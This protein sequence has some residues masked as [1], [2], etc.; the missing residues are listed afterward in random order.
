MS[1]NWSQILRLDTMIEYFLVICVTYNYLLTG[2][3]CFEL[4]VLSS[5]RKKYAYN[6][7]KVFNSFKQPSSSL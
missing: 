6:E 5:Y 7:F 4:L 1:A 3:L 2:I